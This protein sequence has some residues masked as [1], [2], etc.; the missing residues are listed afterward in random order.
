MKTKR[1]L[2]QCFNASAICV[3]SLITQSALAGCN[4]AKAEKMPSD[5]I[6]T[7]KAIHKDPFVQH[8]RD[9]IDGCESGR[10]PVDEYDFN[11][12]AIKDVPKEDLS[13]QFTAVGIEKFLGG[14]FYIYLLA[15]HHPVMY[16]V[17]VYNKADEKVPY[18]I[19]SFKLSSLPPEKVLEAQDHFCNLLNDKDTTL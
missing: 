7:Y 8:I 12:K 6:A 2:N 14:G 18:E 11:C 9:A 4:P 19:R 10:Y 13:D 16:E 5:E 15:H 17:W 3:L 1:R